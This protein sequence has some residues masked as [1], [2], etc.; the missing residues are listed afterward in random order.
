MLGSVEAV[1]VAVTGGL[2]SGK[3]SVC[4]FFKELGAYVV[5]ADDIVHQLLSY[6]ELIG[7]QVID[8]L[9]KDIIA[10]GR[11]DRRLVAK[12][13]F[14]QQNL[15]RSLEKILHTAVL[16]EIER[17]YQQVCKQGRYPLFVVEIPLLF[18]VG[19]E[20]LFDFTIAVLANDKL[21]RQRF[22]A[23]GHNNE[24]YDQRIAN[25]MLPEDKAKHAHFVIENEDD[26]I[27]LHKS[28]E[29]LFKLLCKKNSQNHLT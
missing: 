29:A 10:D 8:L 18:E 15:L 22:I 7:Q 5:S 9:G 21:C 14:D 26:R 17:Q 3:S 4:L 25:Q 27:Q 19:A 16:S 20:K 2:S 11:I 13:V 24:E 1:K 6:N 23:S 12:K 28:V